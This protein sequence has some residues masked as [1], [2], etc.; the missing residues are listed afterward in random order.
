MKIL[1]TGTA[2]G[3]D[4]GFLLSAMRKVALFASLSDEQLCKVLYFVKS[5]AFD[6]GETVFK[7]DDDGDS[8]FV[9]Q[10]GKV[11]ARAP[12]FLGAKT[13]RA[14]GPGEFFGE[15]ALILKQPRSA[16]IVCVEKTICFALERSDLEILMDRDTD[17]AST[18]KKTAKERYE[19]YR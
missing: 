7:K 19:N 13:L 10:E 17:I 18:I 14:M 15:L 2:S 11:E 1:S 16:T 9:I 8:F 6:A 12:G 5:V 4:P 3:G